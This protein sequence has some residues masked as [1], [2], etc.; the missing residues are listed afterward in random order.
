MHLPISNPAS[1]VDTQPTVHQSRLTETY[2]GV[3]RL[4]VASWRCDGPAREPSADRCGLAQDRGA[5]LSCLA[6][7]VALKRL[8]RRSS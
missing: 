1:S 5:G 8:A 7:G 4:V 3:L 2:R 6:R